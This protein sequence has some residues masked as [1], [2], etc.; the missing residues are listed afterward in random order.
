MKL[1]P[2]SVDKFRADLNF[3]IWTASTESQILKLSWKLFEKSLPDT[4]D[5]IMR[6]AI[7]SSIIV[8]QQTN[9]NKKN[10]PIRFFDIKEILLF[11]KKKIL[12]STTPT[13]SPS[14][15]SDS[16]KIIYPQLT[17]SSPNSWIDRTERSPPQRKNTLARIKIPSKQPSCQKKSWVLHLQSIQ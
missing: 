8:S 5:L 12:Q 14:A 9:S 13:T 15:R 2:P 17:K 11:G 6:S 16:T 4:Q 7:S 3:F 1:V 10:I